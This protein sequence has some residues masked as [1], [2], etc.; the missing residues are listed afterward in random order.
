MLIKPMLTGGIAIPV[1]FFVS[2]DGIALTAVLGKVTNAVAIAHPQGLTAWA[3]CHV[4]LEDAS[5]RDRIVE[6][7]LDG[8]QL[9]LNWGGLG[10]QRHQPLRVIQFALI[11]ALGEKVL[12][13]RIVM[14]CFK[15]FF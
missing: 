15:L 7:V 8:T 6:E 4:L 10:F 11:A 14:E 12:I 3:T 2:T 9:S 1:L 5:E 13:E